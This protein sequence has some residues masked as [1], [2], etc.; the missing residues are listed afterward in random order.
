MVFVIVSLILTGCSRERTAVSVLVTAD[1]SAIGLLAISGPRAALFVRAR[2]DKKYECQTSVEGLI[3]TSEG[4]KPRIVK[5]G[6]AVFS[7]RPQGLSFAELKIQPEYNSVDDNF[8]AIVRQLR[9]AG[10]ESGS[11]R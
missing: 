4:A 5:W 6:E 10:A 1:E 3:V 9:L 2:G 11:A 7:D 8:D